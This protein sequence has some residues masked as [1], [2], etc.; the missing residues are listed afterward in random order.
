MAP[1]TCEAVSWIDW[2]FDDKR[3]YSV[4]ELG[5]PLRP[6]RG[7]LDK[8]GLMRYPRHW[9]RTRHVGSMRS[10]RHVRKLIVRVG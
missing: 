3:M 7:P 10:C 2:R 8:R 1:T 9:G 5:C 6:S 4:H